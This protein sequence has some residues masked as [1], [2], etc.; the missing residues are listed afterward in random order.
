MPQDRT[1]HP[2]VIDGA[3]TMPSHRHQACSKTGQAARY[4]EEVL[5]VALPARVTPH[6]CHRHLAATLVEDRWDSADRRGLRRRVH[7]GP[8][9]PLTRGTSLNAGGEPPIRRVIWGALTS[10]EG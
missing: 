10:G 2:S 9:A 3:A 7:G 5:Y 6:V 1:A 4:Q 8:A